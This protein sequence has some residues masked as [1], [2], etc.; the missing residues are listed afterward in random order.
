MIPAFMAAAGIGTVLLLFG[1][2]PLSA[3]GIGVMAVII[4]APILEYLDVNAYNR[5]R[6]DEERRQMRREQREEE[7]KD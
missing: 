7:E 6:K 3:Y 4:G 2:E 1:L 5:G